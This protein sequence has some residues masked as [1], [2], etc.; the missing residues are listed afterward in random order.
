MEGLSNG[1]Y[2]LFPYLAIQV[3][4]AAREGDHAAQEVIGWAGEEL[5]WLAVSVARQIEME[6]E[7]LEIVQSGSVFEAGELITDPMRAFV[8]KHCPQAKLIR[9]NCPPVVGAVILGM[10][11]AGFEGNAVRDVIVKTAIEMV[12]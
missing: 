4:Q 6:N 10:E 11:Q 7:E 3:L 8:L 12:K 5:G 9:L 2:H 1:Q